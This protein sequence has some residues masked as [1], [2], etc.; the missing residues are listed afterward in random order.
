MARKQQRYSKKVLFPPFLITHYTR[1]ALGGSMILD[2]IVVSVGSS[3]VV[4]PSQAFL[5][6]LSQLCNRLKF[7]I[8]NL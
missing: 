1:V 3:A 4:L 8:L 5:V 7:E 2:R 6:W